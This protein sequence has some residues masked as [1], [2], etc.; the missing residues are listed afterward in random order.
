M[1]LAKV[2]SMQ[3]GIKNGTLFGSLNPTGGYFGMNVKMLDK[4][5]RDS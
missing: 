5:R 3:D 4:V 1:K 2:F